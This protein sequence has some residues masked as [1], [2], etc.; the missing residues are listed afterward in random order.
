MSEHDIRSQSRG[1]EPFS[2]GRGGAGNM[3]Q[4]SQPA[5]GSPA[6]RG[7][8]PVPA[9]VREAPTSVGRGGAGNFRSLSKSREPEL[10]NYERNED[11]TFSTGRGGLGNIHSTPEHSRSRSRGPDDTL[12]STVGG[13][14]PERSQSR[15]RNRIL[16]HSTGRGGAGN[17][18]SLPEETVLDDEHER[19]LSPPREQGVHSTGRGGVANIT[20]LHEP[21]VEE[22]DGVQHQQQQQFYSTGRGGAGNIARSSSRGP[23]SGSGR[24][25]SRD[26][27]GK[28]QEQSAIGK[29]IDHIT[30]HGHTHENEGFEGD[31]GRPNEKA[32]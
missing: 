28:H 22:T 26:R 15:G 12:S 23:R 2:T 7:R 11:H 3:R 25:A 32:F 8:E 30:G 14:T 27:D 5:E 6:P 21:G 1:R 18:T 19:A 9:V 16:V 24:S 13:R 20:S 10:G 17:I 31:R 4:Q 29:F